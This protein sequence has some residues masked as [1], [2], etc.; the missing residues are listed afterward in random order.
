MPNVTAAVSKDGKIIYNG[1]AGTKKLNGEGGAV[2]PNTPSRIMSMT[3]F[4]TSVGLLQLVEQGKVNP[5]APITDYLP[6][7]KGCELLKG[8]DADGK[9]ITE[10]PKRAPTVKEVMSHSSGYSYDFIVA[11]HAKY[12]E[13]KG[14]PSIFAQRRA[15]IH[16][17]P[18]L[19][20]PGEDWMYS[21]GIDMGGFVI[22][23]VTGQ[24]LGEYLKKNVFDVLGMKDTFFGQ[25]ADDHEHHVPIHL[26]QPDEA[27]TLVHLPMPPAEGADFEV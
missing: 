16:G 18:L 14:L 26:R 25:H 13:A 17:Q 5:D 19:F 21:T 22:E 1:A 4:L 15:G 2:A 10:A 12:N 24:T 9:P 6:E 11:D 27:G 3:K 23:K 20:H 8:F 7:L